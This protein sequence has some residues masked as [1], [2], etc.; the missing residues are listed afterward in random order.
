[1]TVVI[2]FSTCIANWQTKISKNI[3]ISFAFDFQDFFVFCAFQSFLT[4][5]FAFTIN[6]TSD[7]LN[8]EVMCVNFAGLSREW[9]HCKLIVNRLYSWKFVEFVY[10]MCFKLLL[11]HLTSIKDGHN[12][13]STC[14]TNRETKK[15]QKKYFQSVSFV[16]GKFCMF[17]VLSK[18][19]INVICI[20]SCKCDKWRFK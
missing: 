9:R 12:C 3:I 16:I 5:L 1:M 17:F 14:F 2:I 10:F 8:S 15:Y 19:L 13:F 6:V 20:Y 7:V 18:D 11:W 4:Y